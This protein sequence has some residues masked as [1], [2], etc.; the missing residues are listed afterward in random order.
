MYPMYTFLRLTY[1][2]HTSLGPTHLKSVKCGW[3]TNPANGSACSIQA[4]Q[5]N[6][7]SKNANVC[8]C[9]LYLTFFHELA[10]S[11]FGFLHVTPGTDRFP[12]LSMR[13][14]DIPKP[15]PIIVVVPTRR[16]RCNLLGDLLVSV[17]GERRHGGGVCLLGGR[18]H[19]G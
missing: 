14:R 19:G 18:F 7:T 1:P 16:R 11:I 10:P 6:C 13:N 2:S 4:I 17:R 5:N 8:I 3:Q 12:Q 9:T 15:A